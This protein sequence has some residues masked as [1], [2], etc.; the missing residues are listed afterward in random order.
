LVGSL[1][2]DRHG[3]ANLRDRLVRPHSADVFAAVWRSADVACFKRVVAGPQFLGTMKVVEF[4]PIPPADSLMGFFSELS[5]PTERIHVPPRAVKHSRFTWPTNKHIGSLPNETAAFWANAL[6]KLTEPIHLLPQYYL[7][8]K[9]FELVA[10]TSHR[11]LVR[12]RSDLVFHVPLV[13]LRTLAADAIHLEPG[14]WENSQSALLSYAFRDDAVQPRT[15][16]QRW[17]ENET[18]ALER[19]GSRMAKVV[20]DRT[21][22]STAPTHGCGFMPNDWFAYGDH[23]A[24]MTYSRLLPTLPYRFPRMLLETNMYDFRSSYAIKWGRFL[25]QMWYNNAE[26]FLG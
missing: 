21:H 5:G 8:L 15:E 20:V 7:I 6:V 1:K 22:D 26:G 2:G 16:N 4:E 17:V 3:W 11:L 13:E 10:N 19:L 25:P 18:A 24:M 23:A 12:V 9:A 14:R